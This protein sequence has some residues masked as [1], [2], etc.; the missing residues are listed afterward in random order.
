VKRLSFL[1]LGL[2]ALVLAAAG[3]GLAWFVERGV[4]LT[5]ATA[6]PAMASVICGSGQP[7]VSALWVF[8]GI[9]LMAGAI[10]ILMHWLTKESMG[11]GEDDHF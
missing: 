4:S 5:C 6:S 7:L 10:F 8:P 9:A 1:T 3:A 11:Y 2:I